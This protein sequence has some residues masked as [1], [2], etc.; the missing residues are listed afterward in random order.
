MTKESSENRET[1][2][3]KR[4]RM[5]REEGDRRSGKLEGMRRC[6]RTNHIEREERIGSDWI[7]ERECVWKQQWYR[8][9]EGGLE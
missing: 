6:V 8:C 3:E 9:R 2:N 1:R 5:R 4:E 7:P